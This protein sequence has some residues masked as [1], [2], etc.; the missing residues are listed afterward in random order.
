MR[1]SVRNSELFEQLISR[2]HFVSISTVSKCI[3]SSHMDK[4]HK[5]SG[6]SSRLGTSVRKGEGR[7]RGGEL[8]PSPVQG[9]RGTGRKIFELPGERG[10]NFR[11]PGSPFFF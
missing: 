4:K 3:V 6:I 9:S 10:P 11:P 1:S 2:L 7:N 5:L 8:P